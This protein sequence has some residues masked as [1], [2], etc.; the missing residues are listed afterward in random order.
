MHCV[1]FS[2]NGRFLAAGSD[3]ATA[4]VWNVDSGERVALMRGERNRV[5]SVAFSPDGTVL[6]AG[7]GW[8]VSDQQY[9][10]L[11]DW[12]VEKL[13]RRIVAHKSLL[14]RVLFSPDGRKFASCSG[15]VRRDD[16][17]KIWTT[18]N[19]TALV[20]KGHEESVDDIGFAPDGSKIVS[21]SWD[22]TVRLW[23]TMTGVPLLKVDIGA[24]VNCVGFLADG[25]RVYSAGYDNVVRIWDS[26]SG[27]AATPTR[28]DGHDNLWRIAFSGDGSVLATGSE[29]G[30]IE[31]WD[32]KTG[33][34]LRQFR[35]WVRGP[36]N[37]MVFSTDGR[38]LVVGTGHVPWEDEDVPWEGRSD[39]DI[40]IFDVAKGEIVGVL[41][42]IGGKVNPRELRYS[43]DG[44]T[45]L[46]PLERGAVVVWDADQF[47]KL[48]E[49]TGDRAAAVVTA[50]RNRSLNDSRAITARLQAP[51]TIFTDRAS[52]RDVAWLSQSL[53]E[54]TPHPDGRIW[55]GRSDEVRAH[56]NE[57]RKIEMVAI[58]GVPLISG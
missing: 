15:D 42:G 9:V 17:I 11:W 21:G 29:R 53:Y 19:D 8:G 1:A 57:A 14:H 2:P 48:E 50:L 46:T 49:R 32:A 3:D 39:F 12:R 47:S 55:A 25:Q 22:E 26:L 23:D 41:V 33:R 18:D 52:G 45:I 16:T 35:P 13:L 36:V 40:R 56:L 20:L 38:S 30:A 27:I 31:L 51:E 4:I 34:H 54:L 6:L 58:E 43:D 28:P 24:K 44:R 10:R 37:N 5:E 7:A